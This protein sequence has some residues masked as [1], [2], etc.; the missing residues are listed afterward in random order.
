[1]EV[2]HSSLVQPPCPELPELDAQVSKRNAGGEALPPLP[3]PPL[4]CSA[5]SHGPGGGVI[6]LQWFLCRG[7]LNL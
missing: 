6:Q 7:G 1:M 5:R 4:P 3:S 2:T